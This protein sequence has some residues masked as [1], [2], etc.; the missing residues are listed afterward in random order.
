MKHVPLE[1]GFQVGEDTMEGPLRNAEFGGDRVRR[2]D[3]DDAGLQMRIQET[4]Q[5][6]S[7]QLV[8]VAGRASGVAIAHL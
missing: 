6:R 7:C 1:R 3:R 5:A 8:P 4:E 2:P